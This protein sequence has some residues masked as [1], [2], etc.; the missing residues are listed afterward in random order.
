MKRE[1]IFRLPNNITLGQIVL[2]MDK[3]TK[4][5]PEQLN[6]EAI[7]LIY[8]ALTEAYPNPKFKML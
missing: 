8:L 6:L 2:I 5:H 7:Q 4:Q 1:P 3:Y